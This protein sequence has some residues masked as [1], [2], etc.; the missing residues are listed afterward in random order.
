MIKNFDVSDSF[1]LDPYAGRYGLN[2][3]KFVNIETRKSLPPIRIDGDFKVFVNKNGDKKSFSLAVSVDK[4]NEE[5]FKRL[6]LWLSGLA[7]MALPGTKPKDLKLIKESKNY[8]NVYCKIYTYP[9]GAPKCY[10]SELV[11]IALRALQ[12]VA[13]AGASHWRM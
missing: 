1:I 13:N 7:C 8:H 9:R 3:A 10:Y 2:L 12:A 6:E 5:F 11:D 4:T